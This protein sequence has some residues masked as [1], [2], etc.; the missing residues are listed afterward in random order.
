LFIDLENFLCTVVGGGS[1]A[2][3]KIQTLLD[4]G[5]RI[6]VFD[7]EPHENLEPLCLEHGLTLI[8]RSY[9]GP[10]DIEGARLVIA[11]SGDRDA[12]RRV[13]RDA[14]ALGIPV[15]AADDPEACTFFFPAIVRR[16]ELVAGLS[17]SGGCPR[18]TARLRQE[19]EKQWP[20]YWAEALDDL[21]KK[22]RRLRETEPPEKALRIM[23]EIITR[24]L[25]R[26]D[27]ESGDP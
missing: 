11:A 12:N 9:K 3:R 2:L 15:N 4:F 17:S 14:K 13:S 1:V 27:P 18:F 16:G 6:T 26:E 25:E 20:A 19:L 24:M 23:D 21:G 22:R 10:E 7:P 5:A 8:R